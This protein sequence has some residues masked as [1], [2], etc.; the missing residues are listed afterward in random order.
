MSD[1]PTRST[2]VLVVGAGPVGLFGALGAIR[3]GLDVLILDQSWQGFGPG[4]AAILHPRS[5]RLLRDE[6]IGDDVFSAGKRIENV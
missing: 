4:H 3:R 1:P 2:Q 6:G 5:V